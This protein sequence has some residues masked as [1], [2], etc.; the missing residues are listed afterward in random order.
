MDM[1]E[2]VIWHVDNQAKD[3][4]RSSQIRE[5]ASRIA[6]GETVAFPTETV[7]GL[8]A[9]ALSDDAVSKIFEA[10]GRPSDNPLIAHIASESQLDDLVS[11]MP[12]SARQLMKTFWP[13]PLTLIFPKSSR[14]ADRVTAGL[15]S[16]AVRMPDHPVAAALIKASGV[17]IAAPSANRSGKPSPTTAQHVM[18][19]LMGRI[20]GIIDGG[21]TGIGVEST[22]VDTTT[23]PVTL[24]RPGGVTRQQIEGVL[25]EIQTVTAV[26]DENEKPKSPGMKYRHYAPEA[27]VFL[28]K[29]GAERIQAAIANS[30]ASGKRVGVLTTEENRLLYKEADYVTVAGSRADLPTVAHGLFNA[31]RSFNDK[32]IDVIYSEV[33]PKSGIGE[34][35]MNRLQKAAGG[36]V[37]E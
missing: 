19:D 18:A 1:V 16:V 14:V 8:G 23:N 34:A 12:D 21:E 13:G 10:K 33:F 29:G 11:E 31:L 37:L 36:R 17:P 2:T 25:G 32:K 20:A 24:L 26:S 4:E 28:V 6:A 35:I 27:P 30:K 3:L 22:V 5:A 15:D 7:Y 9:N